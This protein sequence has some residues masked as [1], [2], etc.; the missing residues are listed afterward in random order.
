VTETG[1]RQFHSGFVALVGRPN[2]GK[3]TLVNRLVGET[4]SI[5]APRPQTTRTRVRGILNRPGAQLVLVD[6][7]GIHERERAVNQF[8]LREI[9]AAIQEAD[10]VLCLVEARGRG[11]I[12]E[13]DPED[14][15]LWKALKNCRAPIVL[16]INKIDRVGRRELLLPLMERYHNMKVFSEIIPVSA[17]TGESVARLADALIRYLPEGPRYF[18]D[19]VYTDQSERALVA[20]LIRRQVI[21]NTAEE[22][23]YSSAVEIETFQELPDRGLV[24]LGAVIY[25][26]KD[27]QKGI[28][29]GRSGGNLR[30]IGTAARRDIERILGARVFL[31]LR[32]KVAPNWSRTL[33][34]LRSVGFSI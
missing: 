23:P 28:V 25:V 34:G 26:E 15:I 11:G 31:E 3:S 18:P 33:R 29:I 20:E 16:G 22:I 5:V 17:L 9:R 8:M 27:S 14:D 6:T 4:V 21:L 10:A 12:G 19:E 30:T 2:V 7:P 1:D 32:V 13:P 24:R